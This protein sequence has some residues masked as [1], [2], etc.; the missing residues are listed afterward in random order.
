MTEQVPMTDEQFNALEV[1]FPDVA[2]VKRYLEIRRF[3]EAEAAAQQAHIAPHVANMDAI[4]NELHRRLLKRNPSWQPGM[5]ANGSTPDGTFFLKTNNSVKVA[6]RAA[7]F[8]FLV[9]DAARRVPEF[10]TAHVAKEAV[11]G[12]MDQHKALPPGVSI[13]RI[14][15]LEVRKT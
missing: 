14:T 8:G 3:L 15:K 11:E 5:K 7:F 6:D 4:A 2:L 12:Y 13:D 9:E 10:A 1:E